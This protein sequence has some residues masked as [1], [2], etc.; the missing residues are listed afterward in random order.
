MEKDTLGDR[1]EQDTPSE[2]ERASDSSVAS[3]LYDVNASDP[4]SHLTDR[5]ALSPQ[6]IDQLTRLMNAMARMKRTEEAL[7]RASQEYM[8]LSETE[9]RAVHYL[10]VAANQGKVAT[11]GALARHLSITSASTTK[12]LDRLERGDH[13]TRGP[14]PTDRRSLS[15]TV[16]ERT[17]AVARDTVGRAHAER[18]TVAAAL[19]PSEREVV[20][21]FLSRVA[22]GMS[23]G[24]E[25]W[26][27]AA[28]AD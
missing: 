16:T 27:P 26:V 28:S 9:M 12:L 20:I 25:N 2:L 24:L 4:K 18:F 6:D 23:A 13:I 15:I 10:I 7:S 3:S 1:R 11:P 5:S 17:H 22:D 14:H 21:D 8:Q 19:A